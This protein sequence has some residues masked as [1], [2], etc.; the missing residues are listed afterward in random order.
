[1]PNV[2]VGM[3][4]PTLVFYHIRWHLKKNQQFAKY[5]ILT[6]LELSVEFNIAKYHSCQLHRL[7][8]WSNMIYYG[9]IYVN[10][11]PA[12]L[13]DQAPGHSDARLNIEF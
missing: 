1:M 2:K 7:R 4:G 11:K 5:P 12:Y 6:K 8:Q 9:S 10:F 3:E 13:I